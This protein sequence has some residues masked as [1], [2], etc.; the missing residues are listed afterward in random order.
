[1]LI[2]LFVPSEVEAPWAALAEIE[3]CASHVV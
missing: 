3:G 1:L 2:V